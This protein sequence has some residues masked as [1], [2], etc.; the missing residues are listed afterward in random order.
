VVVEDER[1][2]A[3]RIGVIELRQISGVQR[4]LPSCHSVGVHGSPSFES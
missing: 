3:R 1:L 4:S 2:R